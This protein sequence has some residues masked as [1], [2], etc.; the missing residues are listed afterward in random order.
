MKSFIDCQFAYSQLEWMCYDK[1]S[2]D[3]KVIYANTYV[4]RFPVTTYQHLKKV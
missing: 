4:G 3:F 2:N 1:T